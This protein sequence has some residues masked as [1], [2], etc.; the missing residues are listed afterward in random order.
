MIQT[1]L[2]SA[3]A[4]EA[5]GAR[6]ASAV[7]AGSILYLRGDLG[8]GKTT[9]VRGFIR[10]LGHPGPVKS[11]T[12]TLLEPYS[13]AGQQI[14]HLDLYRLGD[15]EELEFIGLRDC[16]DGQVIVLI[17]WPERGRGRLPAPDLDIELSYAEQGRFCRIRFASAKAKQ[18]R[19]LL[20]VPKKQ[21]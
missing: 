7:Q 3:A 4:T 17:E 21:Q 1:S 8:A 18:L 2:E 6:L 12:Y 14:L 16:L 13:L 15:P 9:L 19:S 11:P 10:A 5:L 20:C